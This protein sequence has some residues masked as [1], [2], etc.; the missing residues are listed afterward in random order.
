MSSSREIAIKILNNFFKSKKNI[1]TILSDFFNF[2]VKNN[3]KKTDKNLT[4]ELVYGVIRWQIYIDW[5]LAKYINFN[6]TPPNIINILRITLYQ[7]IYLDKIPNY[8]SCNEAVKL[9]KK[10]YSGTNKHLSNLVNA[11]I[12]A[13]IIDFENNTIWQIAKIGNAE[14]NSSWQITYLSI[15]YSHPAWLVSRICKQFNIEIAEKIL[16]TNNQKPN[17][18]IRINTIKT[19][20]QNVYD[21]IKSKNIPIV[22]S[23]KETNSIV[24]V[25]SFDVISNSDLWKNSFICIQD[26]SSTLC[27]LLC[28]PKNDDLIFDLC[29]APGG[30]TMVISELLNNYNKDNMHLSEVDKLFNLKGKIICNDIDKKRLAITKQNISKMNYDNIIFSNYDLFEFSKFLIKENCPKADIILLDAP[31]SGLGTI[32][33]NVDIKYIRTEEQIKNR[34]SLQ[35]KMLQKCTEYLKDG[36]H[37]IYSVCSFDV[38]E[39]E[40]IINWLLENDTRFQLEDAK[41]FI[42]SEFTKE[43]FLNTIN[44][45]IVGHM[46]GAFAAR[47]VFNKK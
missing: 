13:F 36:G 20:F 47:L 42:S 39:G 9:A 27:A 8:A 41:D 14:I 4:C 32:R 16:N 18:P 31:C 11:V 12:H 6:K 23:T 35:R 17:L 21:T 2:S 5:L 43:K 10:M 7:I 46:N 1:D 33:K 28:N 3:I 22:Y 30:K 34:I 38:F 25:E 44:H 40:N 24:V 29:A 19:T 45:F 26:I 15:K 37:L